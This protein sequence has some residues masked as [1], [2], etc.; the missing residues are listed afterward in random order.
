MRGVTSDTLCMPETPQY[1]STDTRATHL[2]CSHVPPSM[3]VSAMLNKEWNSGL[4]QMNR[5]VYSMCPMTQG[6]HLCAPPPPMTTLLLYQHTN[7]TNLSKGQ[8]APQG[9][10]R[11]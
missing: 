11:E 2:S 1:F 5:L 10:P 7:K 8:T 3:C 9:Q 4:T 6:A